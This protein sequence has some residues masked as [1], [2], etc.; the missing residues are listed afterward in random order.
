MY[1]IYVL[2]LWAVLLISCTS[3]VA[4]IK[5]EKQGELKAS[6]LLN[7][8]NERKFALDEE[9]AAK[10]MYMQLYTDSSMNRFL[11]LLNAYNN[12]IYVFD[13]NTRKYIKRI[14]YDQE[15]PNGILSPQAYYIKNWD[16]I[17][18]LDRMKI[19]L[20]L[21]DS[22]GN[23][24][25]R[26]PLKNNM[27]TEWALYY[28]QYELSTINHIM[29]YGG[30]LMLC[31]FS[32]FSLEKDNRDKFR[33]TACVDM[34]TGQV[35]YRDLYP[36]ALYG[37]DYNWEGAFATIVYPCLLNDGKLIY[38]FPVSHDLYLYD[39][40][41]EQVQKIYGGS[42]AAGT[43]HSINHERKHTPKEMIMEN[44]LQ[45]DLYGGILYDPYR[46]IYY[47]FML[48]AIPSA[49][50]ETPISDK[51]ICVIMMDKDFNY[52]GETIIGKYSDWKWENSFVTA[53]GLHI[54]C[55]DRN[56]LEEEYLYFKVFAPKKLN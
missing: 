55:I 37:H 1:K 35:E 6:Y 10:P 15:G 25:G 53:E 5:N 13:Y 56:D 41:G 28:P 12:S 17:Y 21:T 18:V 11:T 45:Q 33:F 19:E 36:Q 23:C 46:E 8:I 48:S 43:I 2:L 14:Q 30:K 49:T 27:D 9:T 31:G 3:N 34:A 52:M 51:K 24:H 54:E 20:V 7:I 38:S 16:S 32:P 47:R 29:E 4:S 42:N 50:H 22:L 44:I 40:N 39:L 26:M